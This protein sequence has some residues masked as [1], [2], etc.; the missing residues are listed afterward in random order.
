LVLLD[1]GT[2]LRM[3]EDFGVI[4]GTSLTLLGLIVGF[5]FSMAVTRGHLRKALEEG[6]ANAIGTEQVR[7]D[8]LPP[9]DAANLRMLLVKY[10]EQRI[11]FYTTPKGPELDKLN[12]DTA[13]VQHQLCIVA[14]SSACW[15]KP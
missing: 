2:G 12:A 14:R 1:T 13:K 4:L 11:L 8:L 7:A 3:S 15:N 9:E 6:E 10:L 5:T